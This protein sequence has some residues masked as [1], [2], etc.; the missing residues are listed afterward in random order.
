MSTATMSGIVIMNQEEFNRLQADAGEK[1][2]SPTN[3][4][5]SSGSS[6]H[7][8]PETSKA[9]QAWLNKQPTKMLLDHAD[10]RPMQEVW[11]NRKLGTKR[12]VGTTLARGAHGVYVGCIKRPVG[13]GLAITTAAV[14][15]VATLLSVFG[16]P[17]KKGRQVFKG[18]AKVTGKNLKS[19]G[20]ALVGMGSTL[21]C[22]PVRHFQSDKA[23][24]SVMEKDA[25]RF[26]AA[27]EQSQQEKRA[28]MHAARREQLA[29]RASQKKVAPTANAKKR[30]STAEERN[31]QERAADLQLKTTLDRRIVRAF[32]NSSLGHAIKE[33]SGEAA[34]GTQITIAHQTLAKESEA[35]KAQEREKAERREAVGLANTP[36][37]TEARR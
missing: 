18:L 25:A 4:D 23:K 20:K 22:G 34:F 14:T 32:D 2:P 17:S 15:G 33:L 21:V 16:C 27:K 1:N 26:V 3:S 28:A 11:I 5:T 30:P 7:D 31:A 9:K 10:S 6:S 8:S 29:S 13:A 37:V 36:T 19:A 24:R 35:V 12:T